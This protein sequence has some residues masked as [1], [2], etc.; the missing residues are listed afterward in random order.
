MEWKVLGVWGGGGRKDA[1]T[2]VAEIHHGYGERRDA[3]PPVDYTITA[4]QPL[5]LLRVCVR[6]VVIPVAET[7]H[8]PS[9]F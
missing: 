3:R 5:L 7:R 4:P 9:H 2:P 8:C 1:R 6:G